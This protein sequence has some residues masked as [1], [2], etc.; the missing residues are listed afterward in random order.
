[1]SEVDFADILG[2]KY[3][4]YIV[5]KSKHTKARINFDKKVYDR[6][7]HY[8]RESAFYELSDFEALSNKYNCS[9]KSIIQSLYDN[10]GFVTL[11]YETLNAKQ[12]LYIGKKSIDSLFLQDNI[13]DLSDIFHSYSKKIGKV[14][15]TT[16]YSED[17]AQDMLIEALNRGDIIEN[18]GEEI[19]FEYLKRYF[20]R[21]IKY[22]HLN[23]LKLSKAMSLD[24]ELGKN[25]KRER[26]SKIKSR[27]N[28]EKTAIDSLDDSYENIQNPIQAIQWCLINGMNRNE[29]IEYV[30]QKY[31]L[32]QCE[33]LEIL[34]QELSS[35]IKI[36][37]TAEGKVY[38]GEEI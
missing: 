35:R 26:Y 34:N 21:A 10:D 38:L 15:H 33:L 22:Q 5:M 30:E 29:S 27:K 12:K 32:T 11:M 8:F 6:I 37:E 31:K 1:M 23:K 7:N 17:I 25:D 28:T 13:K 20:F 19:G 9:I 36:R 14:L 2:I 18:L 4:N 16:Q 24:E 3:C